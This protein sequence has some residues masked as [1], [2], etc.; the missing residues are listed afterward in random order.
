MG[1]R[2]S[3]RFVDE[4]EAVGLISSAPWIGFLHGGAAALILGKC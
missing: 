1:V 3:G 2:T 4:E